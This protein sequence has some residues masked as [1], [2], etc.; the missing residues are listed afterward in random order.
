MCLKQA[1]AQGW[2]L[3]I[4]FWQ[5]FCYHRCIQ[6]QK[7]TPLRKTD[8]LTVCL[9]VHWFMDPHLFSLLGLLGLPSPPSTLALLCHLRKETEQVKIEQILQ[10]EEQNQ[11][12]WFSHFKFKIYECWY[13]KIKQA[14]IRVF[15]CFSFFMLNTVTTTTKHKLWI[16]HRSLKTLHHSLTLIGLN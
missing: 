16:T 6:V 2:C 12:L 7:D 13:I 11:S 8:W 15:K 9:T 1:Q 5:I 10:D 3:C 14:R 4:S